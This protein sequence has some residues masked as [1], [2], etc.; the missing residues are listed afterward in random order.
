[1]SSGSSDGPT[2]AR[3]VFRELREYALGNL[4]VEHQQAFPFA[5]LVE[6]PQLRDVLAFFDEVYEP[7]GDMPQNFHNT[8]LARRIIK[9]GGTETIAK[10]IEQ[11]DSTRAGYIS[12]LADFT[13]DVSGMLTLQQLESWLLDD[14]AKMIYLA[15][16]MGTGKTDLAHLMIEV[17]QH[18]YAQQDVEIEARTNIETSELRTINEYGD[19]QE[20]MT[21]GS[22][23][24]EKWFI[25]DEASSELSGYSHDRAKVEQLMSSMVKKMR[26]NGVSMIIIGH[27]GM[28]LHPDLRRLS[29]FV[30]K[31]STK[32]ADAYASV[33][34][35]EGT[36]HLFRLDRIPPTSLEYDTE[37]EAEWEWGD[38]LEDEKGDGLSDDEFREWRDYRIGRLYYEHDHLTQDDIAASFDVGK[39]TVHRACERY[40]ADDFDLDF[41]ETT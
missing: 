30:K 24:D 40:E 11:G 28:D 25:F 34:K 9:R 22:S 23:D 21:S 7:T 3:D 32:T 18:R 31:Q 2:E 26:K 35:G 33:K 10:A 1:M 29:D 41:L 36:G 13:S 4:D 38:A 37:D 12:G 15:G 39:T 8:K 14:V 27:T 5:G 20:W 6:D 16:H 19:L 17:V